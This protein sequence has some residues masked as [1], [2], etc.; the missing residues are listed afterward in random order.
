MYQDHFLSQEAIALA[1]NIDAKTVR[2][3]RAEARKGTNIWVPD[4]ILMNKRIMT[5]IESDNSQG[6]MTPS[7]LKNFLKPKKAK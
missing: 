5:C 3:L 4:R 1:K 6:K 2:I 7:E